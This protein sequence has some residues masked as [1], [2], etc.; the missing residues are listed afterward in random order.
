VRV[1]NHLA[2]YVLSLLAVPHSSPALS[3]PTSM[4]NHNGS[5]MSL[6]LAEGQLRF[7]Y[8]E[9]R[10]GMI[11]AGARPGSQL[12]DGR[13]KGAHISGSARIFA[14][15]CGQFAYQVDGEVSNNGTQITLKGSA[16]MV[17]TATCALKGAKPGVLNFDLKS[18]APIAMAVASNQH[19]MMA[20]GNSDCRNVS[21]DY[22]VINIGWEDSIGGL[23]I[24]ADSNR[25]AP[26]KGVI[27]A[28]GTGI[29]IGSCREN[30]WCEVRYECVAGWS[31][32][33]HFLAPRATR[34]HQVANVSPN[35]PEGLN[36]RSGPGK[37][38]L[39]TGNIPYDGVGI[40]L[41]A[42]Q[43]DRNWCLVTYGKASG[44]VAQRL[45]RPMTPDAKD[46]HGDSAVPMIPDGG[47]FKVPVT[48]NGQLTLNFIVDSGASDVSIPADVVLTLVRT[49]TITKSDFLGK[50]TYQLGDGS[51]VPSQQFLI[52]SLKVGDKMLE[53]VTGSIAPVAANLLLGQSFL[54]RFTS[55]SIDNRKQAL[56]LN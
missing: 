50:Q 16:P 18:G 55:W 15:Q 45:L 29:D 17:E 49:G 37:A 13:L 35:D 12:F 8:V 39:S 44:W 14:S 6:E 31:R 28:A 32:A 19:G 33:D 22:V 34:L 21:G 3:Q 10:P 47:T 56:I 5:L 40:V 7:A 23:A 48:I 27:P 26:I 2:A 38:Y 9:P 51:T 42:C 20:H 54:T 52:R 11:D 43:A 25:Q 36:I 24:R 4:W 30:G 1:I 41:H 46:V 53:N